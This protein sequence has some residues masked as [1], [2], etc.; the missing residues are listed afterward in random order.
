MFFFSQALC[1][2]TLSFKL[3]QEEQADSKSAETVQKP[4]DEM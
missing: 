2:Q 1:N 4:Q 3:P